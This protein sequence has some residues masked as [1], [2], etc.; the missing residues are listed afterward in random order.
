[1]ARHRISAK[2]ETTGRP[3]KPMS[4]SELTHIAVDKM[5]DVQ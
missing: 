1:M 5:V 2:E 3:A 4:V